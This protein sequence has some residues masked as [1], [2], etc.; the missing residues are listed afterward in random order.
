MHV[1]GNQMLEGKLFLAPQKRRFDLGPNQEFN[2]H[3]QRCSVAK[4]H[5]DLYDVSASKTRVPGIC[6]FSNFTVNVHNNGTLSLYD[7]VSNEVSPP[8]LSV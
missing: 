8:A 4:L 6:P 1:V 5:G 2:Y 3:S 7:T